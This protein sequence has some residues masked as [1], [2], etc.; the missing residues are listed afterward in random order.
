MTQVLETQ[1]MSS[2]LIFQ[3]TPPEVRIHLLPNNAEF[4][5]YEMNDYLR[6][7]AWMP[8]RFHTIKQKTEFSSDYFYEEF[9][10]GCERN[11]YDYLERDEYDEVIWD[12]VPGGEANHCWVYDNGYDGGSCPEGNVLEPEETNFNIANMVFEISLSYDQKA[13]KEYNFLKVMDSAWLQAGKIVGDKVYTTRTYSASNVFGTDEFPERICWG[14]NSEPNTLRGMVSQYVSSPFNN[15]LLNLDAFNNNCRF[16]RRAV[17]T[18]N[19][20]RERNYT[21]LCGG[22][23]DAI[24]IVDA[25]NYTPSFFTLLTAGFKPIKKAPHI[26]IVPVKETTIEKFG[27]AFKGYC[28]VPDAVGKSWFVSQD[29]QL[30]GQI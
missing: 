8:D 15:D 21:P 3:T 1:E 12:N 23:C 11:C 10:S 22:E 5:T 17:E 26:I 29:N 6:I 25:L 9:C 24:L 20:D 16:I 28:T 19:Y 18:D 7:Q 4:F 2:S 13:N 30:V 27:V 14:Y